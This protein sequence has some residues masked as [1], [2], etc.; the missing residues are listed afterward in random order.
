MTEFG[1][2]IYVVL[3]VLTFQHLGMGHKGLSWILASIL[4]IKLPLTSYHNN[5]RQFL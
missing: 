3:Y 5:T 1:S 2:R 4:Q